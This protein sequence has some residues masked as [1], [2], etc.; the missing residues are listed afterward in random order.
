MPDL[1]WG[2]TIPVTGIP[3]AEHG[4]LLRRIEAAGYDDLWTSET[5]GYDGFTPLAL[6]AAQT[7][8]LRLATGV[9]NP[10]TRGPAV[11]AQHCAALADAS[12]GGLPLRPRPASDRLLQRLER[13]PVAEPPSPP[14]AG[15]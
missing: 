8:R 2:L 12:G 11:L 4:D 10:F 7:S 3:L 5:A 6:A 14:A 13:R 15:V 1:R 9:V